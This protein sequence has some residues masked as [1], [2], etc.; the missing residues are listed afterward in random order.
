MATVK[1]PPE[2][3]TI[4]YDVSWATY[5]QLLA[6]NID[7][8]APRFTYDRG[9]LEILVALST[10]HEETKHTLAILV[11]MI[12]VEQGID[13]RTVGSM[14]FKRED[15]AQGFEPDVSIYLQNEP[16]VRGV[17]Q[18]DPVI[19]STPGPRDRNRHLAPIVE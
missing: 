16:R 1:S 18:I 7:R 8:P 2:Q 12:A 17:E 6:D 15:L 11:E 4:L 9:T 3:R 19:H 13:I 10:E 14:T 5:E